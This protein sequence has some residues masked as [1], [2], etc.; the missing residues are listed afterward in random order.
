MR[1]YV[2]VWSSPFSNSQGY[3]KMGPYRF[4]WWARRVAGFRRSLDPL[5]DYHIAYVKE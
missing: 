4:L 2:E 5:G 1:Y 3:R